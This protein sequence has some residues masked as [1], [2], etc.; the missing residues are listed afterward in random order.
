MK[1]CCNGNIEVFTEP[2]SRRFFLSYFMQGNKITQK[3]KASI[4][5]SPKTICSAGNHKIV[6]YSSF[7]LYDK[8]YEKV[9]LE[10]Y[11]K[12]RYQL[13]QM[14]IVNSLITS[15]VTGILYHC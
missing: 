12:I 14:S 4:F 1:F 3:R 10:K 6:M 7:I 11:N 13:L 15:I 8:E 2:K 9:Y 5:K